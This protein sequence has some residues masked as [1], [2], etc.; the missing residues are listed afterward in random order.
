MKDQELEQFLKQLRQEAPSA[1]VVQGWQKAV[2][3]EL[4]A[5]SSWQKFSQIVAAAIIGFIIGAA[6]F[7]E[8]KPAE[9][10]FVEQDATYERVVTKL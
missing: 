1:Q 2:K 6:L 10:N 3:R 5:G 7:N 8:E 4:K 9:E